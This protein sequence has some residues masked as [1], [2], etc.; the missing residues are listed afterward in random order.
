MVELNHGG[1]IYRNKVELDFSVNVNPIGISEKIKDR[2]KERIDDCIQY[3]DMKCEKLVSLISQKEKLSEKQVLCGNGASELLL[4]VAHALRPKKALLPVP[5]FGGYE[6]VLQAVQTDI[7]YFLLEEEKNFHIDEKLVDYLQGAK[8]GEIDL[9]VLANPNNP[10]GAAIKRDILE[11]IIR[12]CNKKEIYVLLD[13]CFVDFVYNLGDIPISMKDKLVNYGNLMIL[14]AFTKFYAMPGIR[15][16]Y[17]LCSN[18]GLLEEIRMQLPEWNV[19][20]LAQEAGLAALE[21]WENYQDTPTYVR[22]ERR[23]LL[24]MLPKALAHCTQTLRIYPSVSN[25]ILFQTDLELYSLLLAKGILIRD[26][27]NFKGLKKGFYRIA[28][29]EHRDNERL[30]D[31]LFEI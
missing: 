7:D 6:V 13:E 1:D 3:P 17:L 19:S 2:I 21:D 16:G 30:I 25:Y 18:E 4:A 29:K 31:C 28:V 27:S 23:F 15:L 5:S 11:N 12:I 26:C 8:K 9:L 20:M 24:G 22:E 14:K 10:T